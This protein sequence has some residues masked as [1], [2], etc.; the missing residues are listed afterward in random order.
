VLVIGGTR[1]TGLLIAQRLTQQGRP[2]RVMARD[3]GRAAT[4]LPPGVE[5]VGGDLT[6]E[7]T[8]A[9]V[10]AGVS[11]LVF[12]AGCRSGRPVGEA[13]IIATEYQGVQKTLAAAQQGGLSGR[14]LYM[15][16]SGVTS[17]SFASWALNLY[18]GNTL[19]WRRRAEEAIRSSGLDYT[20]IRAGVLLNSPAGRHAITVTQDDLPL[21]PRYRIAR[22]DVAEAFV[23]ALDHPRASRTTFDIVWGRGTERADWSSLLGRLEP[24]QGVIPPPS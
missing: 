8:L 10:V 19:V 5:V 3:P 4:V 17:R 15:N 13:K 24:D 22:G 6:Q 14:F 9:P 23:A 21:S 16:A 1:G 11:H 7:G 18:K 20:I 12:T 2:V